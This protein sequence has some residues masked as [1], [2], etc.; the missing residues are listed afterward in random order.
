MEVD[1]VNSKW[2][3]AMDAKLGLAG[4]IGGADEVNREVVGG[5]ET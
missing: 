2:I 4:V 1:V 5:D 3:P